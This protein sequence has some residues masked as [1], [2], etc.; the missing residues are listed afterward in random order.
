MEDYEEPVDFQGHMSAFSQIGP[1][2]NISVDIQENG[3]LVSWE[4]PEYGHDIL[5]LYVVRWFLEPEHK[6]HGKAETRNNYHSGQ[7]STN[8]E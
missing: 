5:S 6:L 7:T 2:T 4:K 1:P 8:V 3:F